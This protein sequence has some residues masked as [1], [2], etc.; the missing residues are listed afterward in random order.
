ML[1]IP[2]NL[3]FNSYPPDWTDIYNPLFLLPDSFKTLPVVRRFFIIANPT[4][5]LFS[6]NCSIFPY[7]VKF[8]ICFLCIFSCNF[9]STLWKYCHILHFQKIF[10]TQCTIKR[11]FMD[12]PSKCSCFGGESMNRRKKIARVLPGDPLHAVPANDR[13]LII[14]NPPASCKNFF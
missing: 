8:F 7:Y 4:Q 2:P 1:H 11:L 14:P 6:P 13:R 10:L 9:A 12:S 3:Y 5:S